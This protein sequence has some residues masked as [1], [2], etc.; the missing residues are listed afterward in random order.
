MAQQQ[1]Q[2]QQHR[3]E[4]FANAPRTQDRDRDD[5]RNKNDQSDRMRDDQFGTDVATDPVAQYVYYE[6]TVATGYGAPASGVPPGA[7]GVP[8]YGTNVVGGTNYDPTA[9]YGT[10]GV[11]GGQWG[12]QD[13]T[14]GGGGAG[15]GEGGMNMNVNKG[16]D[17]K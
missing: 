12:G 11:G 9:G 8:D 13:A 2:Q 7:Y 15:G 10:T 16:R 6:T 14:A 5:V 1:Q 3:R 4:E 17:Q